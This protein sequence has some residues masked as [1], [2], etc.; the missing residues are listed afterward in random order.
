M[1]LV[2]S[3][4]LL[5]DVIFAPSVG[6][7]R[8][9][10]LVVDVDD[11]NDPSFPASKTPEGPLV[12]SNS[13]DTASTTKEDSEFSPVASP[14]QVSVAETSPTPF[15][16]EGN[17]SS[18]LKPPT[19]NPVVVTTAGGIRGETIYSLRLPGVGKILAL[20]SEQ[21][22]DVDDL[23]EENRV[24]CDVD[25]YVDE[26]TDDDDSESAYPTYTSSNTE[27]TGFSH[28][29]DLE[30]GN[31]ASAATVRRIDPPLDSHSDP[32]AQRVGKKLSWYNVNMTL[33]RCD[34]T[35]CCVPLSAYISTVWFVLAFCSFFSKAKM[36]DP[37]KCC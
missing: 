35:P 24:A 20:K 14:E 26:M 23:Y 32:F 12:T 2:D 37:T 1:T 30:G 19:L 13:Q 8:K 34:S 36:V 16:F 17:C 3:D 29:D 27:A 6:E 33:V 9:P 28:E 15:A 21:A 5:G 4:E 22:C 31:H 11:A 18:V 25:A 7:D 10:P